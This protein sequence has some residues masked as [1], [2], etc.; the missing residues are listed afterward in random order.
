[1]FSPAAFEK[2]LMPIYEKMISA[3]KK[4]GAKWVILH[5]DGN[6]LPIL[7]MLIEAGIDGIN[8][9]EYAASLDVTEL[10]PTYYGKLRFIGGVCNT[11]VL[12]TND[13]D[14]I[15]EHTKKIASTGKDGGLVIGTHSIGPEIEPQSYELYRSIIKTALD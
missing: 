3:Y 1:M 11:H 7:D 9:V 8:P 15:T 6:L 5:C 12:P 2:I 10:I 4:A 14:Q 13:P